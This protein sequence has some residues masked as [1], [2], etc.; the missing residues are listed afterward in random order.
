M[1]LPTNPST[2]F[3]RNRF[4]GPLVLTNRTQQHRVEFA[5]NI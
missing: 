5:D 1:Y 4:D 2:Y 3:C